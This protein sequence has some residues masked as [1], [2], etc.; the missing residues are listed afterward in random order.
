MLD[1]LGWLID[2]QKE[3]CHNKITHNNGGNAMD[4]IKI[5]A[6]HVKMVAH[7]G[8][9]GL[10]RENTCPAFVAAG[11]RSYFGVETDVHVTADGQFVILHDE[12]TNHVTGGKYQINVEE[13]P[14]SAVENIVL[15]DLDGS[16]CRR[17]IRIPLLEEYIQI[18]K[19]Y[20]KV[21]VLEVKN[22]FP[23]EDLLRMV[24]LIRELGYLEN[25]IFISF[26]L[27]NCIALRKFLPESKIQWL[28]GNVTVTEEIIQTLRE[29]KLDVD[30]Y[31]PVLTKA[32]VERFHAEG[33]L[34]NCWTCDKKEHAEELIEM[35]V[36]FITTNILE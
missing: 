2:F 6:K 23:E 11:S 34:V 1:L 28:L 31:Y 33:I 8:V 36:D 13:S 12:T 24:A 9:S 20:G 17:D 7:R 21:C 16:T 14:Y 27:P 19:K 29:N 32:L 3:V 35:N 5:D 25:V 26:D 18:C 22:H 15:P 10:E 4:T 30:I